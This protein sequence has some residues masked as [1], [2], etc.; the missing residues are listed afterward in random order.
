[1]GVR[2]SRTEHGADGA[3]DEG[4]DRTGQADQDRL[5]GYLKRVTAELHQTRQRLHEAGEDERE[6]VAIVAMSCRYP[7]G[8]RSPEDLWRLVADG[9]DAIG[10]AP[11]DRGWDLG[12]LLDTDPDGTGTGFTGE[13]GFVHDAGAFDA[14]L[15]GMSPREALATDPQ[16]RILLELAWETFERAGLAPDA[17]R[18]RDVGVFVGTGGQDY[19]DD[20]DADAVSDVVDGYL[21]TGTSAAVLSGRL[22]YTFGLEGPALSVDTACSSS[23]VATHLAAQALRRKEC[24]LALA[25]GA[26]VMSTP[27]PFVAFGKQR[28][29][30]PDGRCKPFAEQADGTGWSE[31]AG[32]LLLER[33]S[34]ARRNGHRVLAIIRGSAVNQDGA[35][36]GLS[37]PSGPA[38]QR[39]IRQALAAAGLSAS[40]VDAV[41]AHGT[42][43]TLGDPIEAHALLATYGQDRPADR[44]LW[45][46]SIKSNIG[47]AQSAAGVSGIIKMVQALRHDTLPRT[48]HAAEPS[49]HIDWSAGRVRLLDEARPWPR[50]A[51]PRRAG[52]SSF[53][54][55]GTNVHLILEEA[56]APDPEPATGDGP[57]RG[58]AGAPDGVPVPLVVSGRGAEALRAQAARLLEHAE[59]AEHAEH[60]THDGDVDTALVDTAYSL[61]TGR[62]SLD[63]RAVVLATD[64]TT[65]RR[66]LA[67]LSAGE[68]APNT[69]SGTATN[70]LTAFLFTG[71]GSQRP[72]MGEELY[73]AFP[74]YAEALDTVCEA[75]DGLLGRPLREVLT[76]RPGTPEAALLD[77]TE[78]TQA[79]LFAVEVALFRL[80]ES[81]SL[82]PDFVAG[83]SI[84]ELAAAHVAGVFSLA[85]ACTLVAARG[86]LMQALPAGGAMVAVRATEEETATLLHGRTDVAVAAVNGPRSVVISGAEEAVLEVAALL[87]ERGSSTRRLRVSHAFHSP[88][89]D[90]MTADFRKVAD[91][92][93]YRAPHIPLVSTLTGRRATA[94]ELCS[95]DYWVRHA[96]ETVRHHDAVRSL[97]DEEVTRFVELGPDGVL[98][99]MAEETDTSGPAHDAPAAGP[100]VL[101]VPLLRAGR[102]GTATLLSAL[103]RMYV[104]GLAPDWEAV[105]AGLGA[106]RTDLPTYAFRHRRYW[107]DERAAGRGP[108]A[109]GLDPADHPL[110]GALTV[111]ADEGG[112][113]LTGRLSTTTRGWLAEHR[114]HGAAVLPGTAFVDLAL[115]AGEQVGHPHLDELTLLAPLPVP[116]G[117][118]IRIQVVVGAADDAGA[119]SFGVYSRADDAPG[120]E[121]G[122]PEWTHHAGGVLTGRREDHARLDPAPWPPSGARPVALDDLYPRLAAAGLDYGPSFH[123][124]RAVWQHGEDVLAEVALP[125]EAGHDSARHAL[126]PAVLD[127][128]THALAASLGTDATSS[129]SAGT[130]TGASAPGRLPFT[131]SG[132]SLYSRGASMLR[133]RFTP[134][135]A[136]AY[137]ADIA[138][139]TGSPVARIDSVTFRAAGTDE[140]LPVFRMD[141]VP[142]AGQDRAGRDTAASADGLDHTV[143]ILPAGGPPADGQDTFEA[144]RATLHK[145]LAALQE[146]LN[147]PSEDQ[148]RLVV[149]T[150]GATA[151]DAATEIDLAGAAVHGLVRSAQTEHPGRLVL[152]DLESGTDAADA[153]AFLPALLDSG[154]PQAAVREGTLHVARLSRVSTGSEDAGAAF[155]PH[156]TVLVTG[157]SG[158]LGGAV[159][160]HLVTTHGANS[161]LLLSRTGEA[162]P[163]LAAL[164][165]RLRELGAVVTTAACDVADRDQ[166]AAALATVP[167]DRPLT[168]VVHAAG[169]LDDGVVS[170]LTPERVDTVLPPKVAGALHLDELTRDADLT[171]FVLFSS[172][173]GIL[174]APGQ[175]NYAAANTFLD[176]LAARRRT[177]GRPALSLAWG[178][179]LADT[180]PVGEDDGT[181]AVH[182]MTAGLGDTYRARMTRSGVRP[183]SAAEGLGLFDA[184]LRATEPTVIPAGLGAAHLRGPAARDARRPVKGGTASTGSTPGVP[185]ADRLRGLP[186][187]EQHTMLLDLVRGHVAAVLGH[188]S[189]LAVEP[190]RGFHELGFD[191]LTAVELRNGLA[192]ATG[193]RLPATLVFDHP[194]VTALVRHLQE[195]LVG[196]AEGPVSSVPSSPATHDEPIAIVGMG[197]RFPG[198]VDS[199]EGLWRLVSEGTDA[200]GEFPEDRGWDIDGLYDPEGVRPGSTY[201][202]HGGFLKDA[203]DFDADF[204]GIS[205]NEALTMDPQQRLLLESSWEALERAGIV[206]GSLRGSGTGVFAGVQYH[207]YVGSNSTGA[208]VSGRVA[209]ALGL[210]GPAVSVDTACSS[211]LV[212]LHLA[213][214]SLR[215]GE[216]SL[217]LAGGVTVMA[218]PETF[219]EFS[220][221]RGLSVDGR[222]RS[223]GA[224][225]GGTGWSE[226]VGV[227]VVERLSDARRLGHEVLAVVAG[228]AVNQDGASNGLTAPN[229]PSQQRVIRA[230]LADA[231][232]SAVDVDVVEAHGT[233]TVLGDPIEAQAL[234]AAYGQG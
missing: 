92:V 17:L 20:L 187:S 146:H 190:D 79:A 215:R 195:E 110:L 83:H 31:G 211:S 36:N 21:S 177:Q 30:A 8:V 216:C 3:R 180:A 37:A 199:P 109:V 41:E 207:D 56:P 58:G 168:G 159:A 154:E 57:D 9:T 1:M 140:R 219:V 221:Q 2:D 59:H 89:M 54:I 233:G 46:G 70:G 191:S 23:L 125:A 108:A 229:G 179:W 105:F 172:V 40:E 234:I 231:G 158:A 183:L 94:A 39:V 118:G 171:A 142:A 175:A 16:Q 139:S 170:S 93:E 22:S 66:G 87:E 174:G 213:V 7:G 82:L 111:L 112:A 97:A 143:R 78:Y 103:A 169:V 194:T 137:T 181:T 156:G 47:H 120:Q 202:R 84:G 28:G 163:R 134:T 227:L 205:P 198:G 33:L 186:E 167:A 228:S 131:W 124:L 203:A 51:T 201:V 34:D 157:A 74:A 176:A 135:T 67:A 164:A 11:T 44:P 50:S 123:G 160:H 35:S 153:A 129:G 61:A 26:M 90:A 223:F 206:P 6:P 27:T 115:W 100:A 119:R 18:G 209:Y 130:P 102:P 91:S 218:T 116:A 55:S 145:T 148:P 212:G 80:L 222:C 63:H 173:S 15:F 185:Y 114:V 133:V 188:D 81:W 43:T 85:D 12:A 4:A 73:A 147:A 96:R 101:R 107:L 49:S 151:G 52:V 32:L 165:T 13:G 162:D 25:G 121:S 5:L 72:G 149:V 182:G 204:F 113:V 166:L 127:A 225:A 106:R 122:T 224:G 76:A 98:S 65:A 178:P 38:Q 19:Y 230:A 196:T 62:A 95:A 208:V 64:R 217:A 197:C 77:E 214:Q 136:D 71:Q 24:S 53:G 232:V 152:L 45:L 192:T 226:G 141:W 14:G 88:L 220:R 144:V 210:E 86:R 126:H 193:V 200:I 29:L 10:P 48:L 60:G 42:G 155:P 138:D 69:F 75:F 128:A 117:D 99:A 68:S 161:L 132:V 189:P 150:T 184:A 104:S